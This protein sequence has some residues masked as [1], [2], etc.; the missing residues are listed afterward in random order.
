LLALIHGTLY[1]EFLESEESQLLVYFQDGGGVALDAAG[2]HLMM[3]RSYFEV[4]QQG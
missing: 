4:C 3:V 1:L 2:Q